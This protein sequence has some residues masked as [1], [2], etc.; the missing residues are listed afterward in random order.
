MPDPIE[1]YY[2]TL[3]PGEIPDPDRLIVA[4]ESGAVRTILAY[5]DN[6]RQ[7]ECIL[8]PGCQIVAMSVT[9]CHELG[10]AYDPSI[11]LNMVSANGNINQSLGLARNVAFQ[12][13]SITFY[14]QVHIIESPAYDVLLGRP[15][16][17]LTES[18]VRNFANQDQTI[19]I[20]DPNSGRRAT[21]PTLNRTIKHCPHTQKEEDF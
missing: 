10:L 6:K 16:D 9:S 4:I 17:I 20:S 8:D 5:I 1:K 15:F 11:I 18:V 12:V 19:T 14:L 3:G 7:K 2:N 13:G 21:V